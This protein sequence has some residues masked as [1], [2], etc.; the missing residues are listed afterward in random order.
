MRYAIPSI[1]VPHASASVLRGRNQRAV[2]AQAKLECIRLLAT[3]ARNALPICG[4]V[5]LIVA[6]WLWDLID[7]VRSIGWVA[8]MAA[9]TGT[10]LIMHAR[11]RA[12]VQD[13]RDADSWERKF[14][15]TSLLN[16]A[17]WGALVL[18]TIPLGEDNQ[19]LFVRAIASNPP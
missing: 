9:L 19:R 2:S 3:L 5:V 10:S 13:A 4:F 11:F 1:R 17:A 6:Y 7:P 14:A 15:V 16:G 8:L 18:L 12:T